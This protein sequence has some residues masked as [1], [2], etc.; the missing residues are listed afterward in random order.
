MSNQNTFGFL[1]LALRQANISR[2]SLMRCS[3]RE[4]VLE[5][6]AIV[7]ILSFLIA[8]IARKNGHEVSSDKMLG[9]AIFH[10]ASECLLGDVVTPVKYANEVIS[11]EFKKLEAEAEK[12]LI[13]TLPEYMQPGFSEAIQLS[14]YERVL[15]KGCDIYASYIKCIT[16]IEAGNR[17]E[18]EDARSALRSTLD[19][20]GRKC[21]EIIEL[22]ELFTAGFSFSVDKLLRRS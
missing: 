7:T 19:E 21:P 13:S 12:C 14:G 10:D 2:W 17:I 11:S 16:E 8:E 9:L 1:A 22:D 15:V 4:S 5:H 20:Y 6:S 3:Q 18:F